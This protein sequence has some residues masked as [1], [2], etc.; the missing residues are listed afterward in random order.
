MKK[1]FIAGYTFGQSITGNEC[2]SFVVSKSRK[3]GIQKAIELVVKQSPSIN[4][5]Q[6][7]TMEFKNEDEMAEFFG[8]RK[9][10]GNYPLFHGIKAT[11][12]M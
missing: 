2:Y 7:E 3:F 9:I 10:G 12:L 6:I 5:P 8:K 1:Y 4:G 11:Q